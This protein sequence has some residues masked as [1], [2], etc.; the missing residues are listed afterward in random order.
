MIEK[1]GLRVNDFS[2]N[3]ING[4]SIEIVC[5]KKKSNQ[6]IQKLKISKQLE[7]EKK[8]NSN[9]YKNL[10]LRINNWFLLKFKF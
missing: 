7:Y 10:N 5:S 1:N 2:F 8:I 9:T 6:K 3:E 4:G